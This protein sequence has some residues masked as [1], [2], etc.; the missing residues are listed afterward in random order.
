[1]KQPLFTGCA[2]A[3][4]TPFRGGKLDREALETLISLQLAGGCEA[5]VVSGT[6]GESAVLS[7]EEH[8]ALVAMAVKAAAGRVPVLAGAGSN[9]T[10]HALT[11]VEQAEESG[12]DGLLLVTPYYNKTTQSGLIAHYSYL[13]D[14]TRLPI[15]LYNVPS[16]TG[17]S[18][19]PDTLAVLSQHPNI[20]GVKEAGTDLDSISQA[21]RC[22]S[23]DF[24]FFSGNDSLTLPMMAMGAK[25]VISVASNLIPKEMSR[26]CRL[27]LSG[28]YSTA[29]A[30]HL[31]LL[32]LMQVLFC[33]VN[34]IP[35]KTALA[36]LGLCAE[37]FRLPLTSIS[38]A[39]RQKLRRVME[40]QGLLRKG[41]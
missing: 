28:D 37:E 25:G 1:M 11:L 4:V 31:K 27:C 35:V 40:L 17:M 20:W 13:A 19:A 30:L 2:T 7:Y 18:I 5:I 39:N 33:E 14:R 9:S 16:R 23:R 8:K 3:I 24:C 32:D 38:P 34:P 10:D 6:T 15:L 12:A 41:A 36:E 29:A 21:M 26:L 22:C